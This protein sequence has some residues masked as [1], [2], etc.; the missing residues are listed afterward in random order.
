MIRIATSRDMNKVKDLHDQFY[1]DEFPLPS[2]SKVVQ[3]LVVEEE[4]EIV[5]FGLVKEIAECIMILDKK[6]GKLKRSRVTRELLQHAFAVAQEAG[7][8]G[9]HAFVQDERFSLFLTKHFGF[10]PSKGEVLV[11]SV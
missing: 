5:G 10:T 4:D 7:H 9:I 6:H 11:R 8:S 2:P 3:A 1:S